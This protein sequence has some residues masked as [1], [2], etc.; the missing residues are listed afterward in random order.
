M[1]THSLD[2]KAS[3]R[4]SEDTT[5][6]L[7]R[8]NPN[9]EFTLGNAMVRIE[10]LGENIHVSNIDFLFDPNLIDFKNCTFRLVSP[11]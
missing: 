7:S 4:Q 6:L 5:S 1:N 11:I 9:A 2:M 10:R 8:W 3:V